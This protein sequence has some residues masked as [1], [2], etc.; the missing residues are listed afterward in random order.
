MRKLER[1]ADDVVIRNGDEIH[2][3]GLGEAIDPLW[4]VVRLAHDERQGPNGGHAGVMR[5]QVRVQ[6]HASLQSRESRHGGWPYEAWLSR[7]NTLWR[8]CI[9]W[10]QLFKH[11]GVRNGDR[12][13]ELFAR[14]WFLHERYIT[15]ASM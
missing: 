13:R 2:A 8:S 7:A 11:T 6:L 1:S 15:H 5:M 4:G 9:T 10:L 3:A 14:R 12:A